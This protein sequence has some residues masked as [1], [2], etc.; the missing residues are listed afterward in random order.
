MRMGNY[1]PPDYTSK[2]VERTR[3]ARET[4]GYDH[5]DQMAEALGVP[6]TTYKKYETR[7]CMPHH[8]IPR[9]CA[10]AGIGY[11]QLF[12]APNSNNQGNARS[13]AA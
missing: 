12:G 11:Q 4:A 13:H 6:K 8:L 5:P 7:T 10:L 9:F 1:K 3:I 2:F